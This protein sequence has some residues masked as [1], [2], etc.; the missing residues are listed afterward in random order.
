MDLSPFW[1]CIYVAHI[2]LEHN[3]VQE[4]PS[5]KETFKFLKF[6]N[7][8]Y[9][10]LSTL[11]T[12]DFSGMENTLETFLVRGNAIEN[13]EDSDLNLTRL[14]RF[15][16]GLNKLQSVGPRAFLGLVNLE[17]LN[18]E[19]NKIT[20]IHA[21]AFLNIKRLKILTMRNN[22]LT[23]IQKGLFRAQSQL[24]YLDI[25]GNN[26]HMNPAMFFGLGVLENLI[27]Q[28]FSLCCI[29]P[30]SVQL[31]NCVSFVDIFSSCSNLLGAG[32]ISVYIWLIATC[33]L[34]A[35][36]C[37]IY[38]YAQKRKW[39]FNRPRYILSSSLMLSDIL[40]GIYL[41]IISFTDISYRGEYGTFHDIW[42]LSKLCTTGGIIATVSIET[43][44]LTTT[45]I[46]VD[47]LMFFKYNLRMKK[48]VRLKS[49]IILVLI[50]ML[51]VVSNFISTTDDIS[52]VLL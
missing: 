11:K 44:M 43:S 29:R 38:E 39:L 49:T 40:L 41:Y 51:A 48:F 28:N 17:E 10:R 3:N 15:D 7:L 12:S 32:Y 27:V 9:N 6:L 26:I 45:A 50:W 22:R 24:K 8:N 52:D 23:Y 47:K 42:R 16:I 21:D 14:Q 30:K 36:V 33:L 1:T 20:T 25:S 19:S 46:T 4:I 18:I 5:L 37:A 35:N 2:N 31:R 13:L 34:C